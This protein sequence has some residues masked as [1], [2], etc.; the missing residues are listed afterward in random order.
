MEQINKTR[1]WFFERKNKIRKPLASLLK[2]KGEKTL[3]NKITN[4]KGEI[5]TN[6]KENLTKEIKDLYPNN[7]RTLLKEIQEDTKRW[8][9]IPCSWIGRINIVKMSMLTQGDLHIQCIPIHIPWT[10]FTFF[11]ELE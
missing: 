4:E 1:S 10:F 3:I 9:N 2:N 6:T 11:R 8:K 5:T 7:Y